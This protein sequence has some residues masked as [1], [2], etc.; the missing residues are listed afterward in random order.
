MDGFDNKLKA[1]EGEVKV[2]GEQP[3]D[4]QTKPKADGD[5]DSGAELGGDGSLQSDY[6]KD[7]TELSSIANKMEN[8]F[9]HI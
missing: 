9:T 6:M 7:I 2:L 3:G 4:V 8:P 1:L 5:A